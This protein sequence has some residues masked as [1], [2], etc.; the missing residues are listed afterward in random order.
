VLTDPAP[1]LD[2]TAD[3]PQLDNIHLA[4]TQIGTVFGTPAYLA[5]EQARGDLDQVD[6]RSDVFGL[7][8]LLCEILTGRAP[9]QGTNSTESFERAVRGDLSEALARLDTVSAP[10]D[11]VRLARQ[12]L[13]PDPDRRPESGIQVAEA[14][15]GYVRWDQ[16]RAERDLVRF[17]DLS[18]DLFCIADTQ[19]RFHRVNDNFTR[20]LGYSAEDLT[21]RPFLDFVHPDDQAR[22]LH[23]IETLARGEP[24]IQFVNR[25]RTALGAY[26]WLEW[27]ALRVPEENAVYAVARDVSDRIR[28]AKAHQQAES[29]RRDAQAAL[30]QSQARVQAL[31]NRDDSALLLLDEHG[32]IDTIT[33]AAALLFG[34]PES[35]LIGSCLDRFLRRETPDEI[36]SIVWAD[37]C[38]ASDISTEKWNDLSLLRPDSTLCPITLTLF[39]SA[40]GS[41]SLRSATIQARSST[42]GP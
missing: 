26:I 13:D 18:P 36:K 12:C 16:A 6:M 37:L 28:M 21:S 35:V 5:P 30:S 7:G 17:F 31:L 29:S 1:T 4:E 10:L 41:P 22:T 2:P 11:L 23:E 8:G 15:S 33:R 38:R 9:H 27:C 14:I 39:A 25:Y 19:G 42:P 32:T 24:T 20:V 3:G 40:P 34:Y